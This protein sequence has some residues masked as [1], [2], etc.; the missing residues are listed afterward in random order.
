MNFESKLK[1]LGLNQSE[2]RIYLY[3]LEHGVSTPP[4]IANGTKIARTNCYNVLNKLKEGGLIEEQTK[5][6]RKVYL[7]TD[8]ASLSHSLER[9][10][11]LVDNMLPDLR[12]LYVTQKNK[13]T[14]KFF[15]GREQVKEI[16]KQSLMTKKILGL[17]STKHYL[18]CYPNF[19]KYYQKQL[20]KRE[21]FFKD[22]LTYESK[23]KATPEIKKVLKGFYDFKF[24]PKKYED[25]PTNILI[26]DD[27]VALLTLEEPFFGMIMTNK[28]MAQTFKIM[29]NI[30]WEKE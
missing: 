16:F 24:F 22:I 6:K 21:I 3:L 30:M 23:A 1:K 27:N 11:E 29:F 26:W 15:D 19:S 12:A 14:I 9:K 20:R 10:K 7:A 4:Q 25:L 8:P 17:G 18:D 5:G 13:P 2:I 28:L